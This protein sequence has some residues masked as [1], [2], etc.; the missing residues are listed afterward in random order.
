MR[1]QSGIGGDRPWPRD[2]D[3]NG[4]TDIAVWRPSNGTWFITTGRA[5]TVLWGLGGDEPVPADYDGDGRTDR[6]V[7]RP[8]TGDWHVLPSISLCMP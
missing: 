4:T 1:V 3:G 6:A 5:L 7:W 2:Y 8:H